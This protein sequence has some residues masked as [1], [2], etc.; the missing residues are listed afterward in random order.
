VLAVGTALRLRDPAL[1][2]AVAWGFDLAMVLTALLLAADLRWGR[3]S[4]PLLAGLALDVGALRGSQP[5]VDGLAKTL[6]DPLQRMFCDEQ[7]EDGAQRHLSKVA[8][9]TDTRSRST[10]A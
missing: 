5:V 10:S 7:L 8:D 9:L 2:S 6:G 3:W 1:E 4:Q